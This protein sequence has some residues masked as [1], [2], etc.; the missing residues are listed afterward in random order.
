LFVAEQPQHT[1]FL[2]AFEIAKYPVTNA[3]YHRFIWDVGHRLPRDWTGFTY[4]D[5]T[6]NHLMVGV[7]KI[8]AEAYIEWL[9][10]KTGMKFKLPTEAEWERAARG[11]DGPDL[12]VGQYVRSMAL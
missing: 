12:S 4:R 1:I 6:E 10:K 3:D 8:D 5:D 9:N 7:S 2:Q 11:N